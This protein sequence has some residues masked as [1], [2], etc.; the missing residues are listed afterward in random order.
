VTRLSPTS[1]RLDFF[2]PTTWPTDNASDLDLGSMTP[3]LT[4]NGYVL[5]A[6]KSGIGYVLR[7]SH[8]GGIGGQVSSGSLCTAFG[9]S[10]VIG[11]TVFLPCTGGVRRVEVASNGT[12]TAGWTAPN[13]VNG[14]PVAGPGAVYSISD[15]RLYALAPDT[16]QILGSV[17]LGSATT[18]F[19]TSAMN[20]DKLYVPTTTG[21]VAVRFG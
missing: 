9:V 4:A 2:A 15:G 8:L 14:S 16:G 13:G 20:S 6:G 7:A 1:D 18:R 12:F 21:V 10:A 17:A 3:A 19:A 11:S 5:Q